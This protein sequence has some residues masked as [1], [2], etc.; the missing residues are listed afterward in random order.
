MVKNRIRRTVTIRELALDRSHPPMANEKLPVKSVRKAPR[1]LPKSHRGARLA[2]RRLRFR[3]RTNGLRF[4]REAS[5]AKEGIARFPSDGPRLRAA[6]IR[7]LGCR[8]LS[9]RNDRVR[10]GGSA[11]TRGP[12]ADERSR[13]KRGRNFERSKF[14]LHPH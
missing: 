14:R 1:A 13:Q 8:S 3:R 12:E 7:K 2:R 4:A 9:M 6:A 5:N 11:I 10:K